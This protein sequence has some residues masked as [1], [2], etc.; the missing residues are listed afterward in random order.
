M[1]AADNKIHL[2]VG[3]DFSKTPGPREIWEGDFSG[4]LFRNT[5]LGPAIK[6]AIEN[7]AILHIDLDGTAGYGTSFLEE[8]FGGLIRHN[9]YTYSQI[10]PHLNFKSDEEPY[11]IEDILEYLRDADQ[12]RK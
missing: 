4:E 8:S 7:D 10:M 5:C 1:T 11:L 12:E 9:N 6:D 3:N 2:N